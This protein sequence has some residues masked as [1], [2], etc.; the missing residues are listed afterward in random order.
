MSPLSM[1]SRW[2]SS[3][4]CRVARSAV[5]SL[6]L[7][8]S[9]STNGVTRLVRP[10]LARMSSSRVVTSSGGSLKAMTG[11]PA[12]GD[13]RVLLPQ[14]PGD[15][16]PGWRTRVYP[17][18]AAPR[19]TGRA[20]QAVMPEHQPGP[21]AAT[22]GESAGHGADGL[23]T[24]G[25]PTSGPCHPTHQAEADHMTCS[26]LTKQVAGAYHSGHPNLWYIDLVI[27]DRRKHKTHPCHAFQSIQ[28]LGWLA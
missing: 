5:D 16:I 15:R 3:A 1:P 26:S 27:T 22:R 8:G 23:D 12:S 25:S 24:V 4:L 6:T 7:T 21:V 13:L 20:A 18:P 9:I 10:T 11:R 19:L 2:T 28:W 17:R 14:R